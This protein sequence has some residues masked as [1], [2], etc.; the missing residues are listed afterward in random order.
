MWAC[1]QFKICSSN[2]I[3]KTLKAWFAIYK[4]ES[5][6]IAPGLK[7]LEASFLNIQISLKNDD[8][9]PLGLKQAQVEIT[10]SKLTGMHQGR[11]LEVLRMEG[12]REYA[13]LIDAVTHVLHWPPK[14]HQP[15][16]KT[17]SIG[18][19][20]RKRRA[21]HRIKVWVSHK[22]FSQSLMFYHQTIAMTGMNG[23][24]QNITKDGA[25]PKVTHRPGV[26]PG[27]S[28]LLQAE[29]V[30]CNRSFKQ[31]TVPANLFGI[32]RHKLSMEEIS[33]LPVNDWAGVRILKMSSGAYLRFE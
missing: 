29:G 24:M 19:F 14:S 27:K 10:R 31:W 23:S 3:T 5:H 32:C 16:L 4:K 13:C 33:V 18:K 28:N 12:C 11:S 21:S 1:A 15:I 22:N 9:P 17:T 26:L 8:I 6:T 20:Q 7:C 30:Q 25:H 2:R